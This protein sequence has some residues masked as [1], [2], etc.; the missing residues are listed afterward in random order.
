MVKIYKSVK[1]QAY[2]F[3]FCDGIFTYFVCNFDFKV[4]YRDHYFIYSLLNFFWLCDQ[5]QAG[6]DKRLA[7]C[8]I[9]YK[10]VLFD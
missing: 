7:N 4:L 9:Y 5:N 3:L 6:P 1:N 8:S 2:Y 10:I